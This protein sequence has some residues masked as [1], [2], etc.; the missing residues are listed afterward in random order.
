MKMAKEREKQAAG[1]SKKS[2]RGAKLPA[3]AAEFT[4]K[5][6]TL[7]ESETAAVHR[8]GTLKEAEDPDPRRQHQCGRYGN[9]GGDPD[10]IPGRFERYDEIYYRTAAE[11]AGIR[12]SDSRP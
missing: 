3:G 2:R 5:E 7:F 4:E 12:G 10:G 11:F 1:S 9:G 8:K 6:E